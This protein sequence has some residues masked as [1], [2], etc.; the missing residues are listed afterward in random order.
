MRFWGKS[1]I[2]LSFPINLIR[3]EQ[4]VT[5]YFARLLMQP[6]FLIILWVIFVL[7]IF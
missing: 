4:K 5:L 2:N 1:I 6:S 3:A 7:A